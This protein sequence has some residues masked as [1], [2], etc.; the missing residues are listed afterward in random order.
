MT[1]LCSLHNKELYYASISRCMVQKMWK[2]LDR[3][4]SKVITDLI[5]GNTSEFRA[6]TS[7]RGLHVRSVN[8]VP[9]SFLGINSEASVSM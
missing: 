6:R 3:L 8:A 5:F 1:V 7:L 9:T 2:V 4:T